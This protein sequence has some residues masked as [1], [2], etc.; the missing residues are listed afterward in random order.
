MSLSSISI[1]RPVLAIVL[2]LAILLFGWIGLSKLGVR[3][4]PV[5]DPPV[6]TVSTDYRGASAEVVESQI[7]E[8]LEEAINSVDGIRTLTSVSREGRS[9]IQVE[10]DLGENLERAANDVRDRVFR[11]VR[12]LP[13]DIDPPSVA[14]ADSDSPPI[15]MLTVRSNERNLLEL[16]RLAD[17]IFVER[18]V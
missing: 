14:K 1:R 2:S 9:T 4:Y 8:P 12:L 7:T 13:P 15:V 10:F 16:S 5:V 6:I 3:E 17:E 18:L 11:T